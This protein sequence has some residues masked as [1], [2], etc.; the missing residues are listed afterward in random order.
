V[1]DNSRKRINGT[2]CILCMECLNTC[3]KNALW[4]EKH[5]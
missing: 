1:T 4:Q 5:A 2:E 3:P